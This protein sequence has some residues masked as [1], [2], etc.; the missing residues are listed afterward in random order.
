MKKLMI[1]SILFIA[2]SMFTASA[3][4]AAD[5]ATI[6]NTFGFGPKLGYYSAPDADEGNFYGGLQARFRMGAV[7]GI[8]AS[9]EY[10]PGQKYGIGNQTVTTSFIPV[11]ASLLLFMPVNQHFTP[12]TV[13]GIGSYYTRYEVS[14]IA[15]EI[16]FD[17]DS[18]FNLGYHLGFGTEIPI[19]SHVALNADY[20]YLFLNPNTNEESFDG[21]NFNGNVFTAGLMFY[22]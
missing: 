12:Y 15:S 21:A 20:R 1:L 10:R 6:Q 9:V 13:A 14:G 2:T 16:G 4:S 17:D 22:F 11:T 8:E 3:Q 18:S 5:R 7:V 19:T